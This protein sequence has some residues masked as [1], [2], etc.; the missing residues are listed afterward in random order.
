M[1]ISCAFA[2]FLSF[3]LYLQVSAPAACLPAPQALEF[4]PKVEPEKKIHINLLGKLKG[5]SLDGL[6]TECLPSGRVSI[7]PCCR[8]LRIAL[9][10]R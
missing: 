2:T 1:F 10:L 3:L 8:F 4:A 6:P 7:T 9:F 5:M